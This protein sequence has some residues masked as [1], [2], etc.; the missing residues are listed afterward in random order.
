MGPTPYLQIGF[1][2][3]IRADQ[4]NAF[5]WKLVHQWADL[6]KRWLLACSNL[7]GNKPNHGDCCVHCAVDA[8]DNQKDGNPK[9]QLATQV[10]QRVIE[11]CRRLN[12]MDVDQVD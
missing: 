11:T 10:R 1:D 9:P 6:F 3:D 8:A 4:L 12:L 5:A 7:K 2:K